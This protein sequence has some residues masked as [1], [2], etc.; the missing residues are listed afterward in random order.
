MNIT[1]TNRL[2]RNQKKVLVLI[3]LL[4]A[5]MLAYALY[6][7]LTMSRDRS[8]AFRAGQAQTDINTL[9]DQRSPGARADGALARAKKHLL[10]QAT[11][12]S[13]AT[14]RVLSNVRPPRTGAPPVYGAPWT[15]FGTD[16]PPAFPAPL[17]FGFGNVGTPLAQLPAGGGGFAPPPPVFGGVPPLRIGP[18]L[19]AGT[20]PPVIAPVPE[21]RTWFT[22]LTGFALI[23]LRLRWRG[24]FVR[25]RRPS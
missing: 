5:G 2:S 19:P 9:L 8:S 25:R 1:I 20:E 3:G 21:T 7:S 24:L 13:P 17:P 4:S 11:P 16:G 12:R 10:A 23:G 15:A 14:Q 18:G 22:L 6:D